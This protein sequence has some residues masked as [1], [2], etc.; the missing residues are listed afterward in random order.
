MLGIGLIFLVVCCWKV[1]HSG[2]TKTE[3]KN[4]VLEKKKIGTQSKILLFERKRAKNFSKIGVLHLQMYGDMISAYLEK[5]AD[6]Y[7]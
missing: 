4:M 1:E 7:E 3:N 6:N 2:T 5:G